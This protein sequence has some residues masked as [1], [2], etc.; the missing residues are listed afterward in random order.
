MRAHTHTHAHTH[1][2]THARARARARAHT[3]LELLVRGPQGFYE[4]RA[5]GRRVDQGHA[6]IFPIPD[7]TRVFKYRRAGHTPTAR[8]RERERRGGR[9]RERGARMQAHRPSQNRGERVRRLHGGPGG[10]M[11][12]CA[13]PAAMLRWCCWTHALAIRP[14][15]R[16]CYSVR[17]HVGDG[18]EKRGAGAAIGVGVS[19]GCGDARP[20]C[21]VV[22]W[23]MVL[24]DGDEGSCRH[25]VVPE[26]RSL[27]VRRHRQRGPGR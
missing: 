10:P 7:H 21:P 22:Q 3:H 19:A 6:K 16:V 1:A 14:V 5:S 23:P 27:P 13:A 26:H 11:V 4:R 2:R 8:A 15:C 17:A 24:G 9:K 18:K 25:A 12:G 20:G